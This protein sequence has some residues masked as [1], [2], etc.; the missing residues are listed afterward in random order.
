MSWPDFNSDHLIV[1]SKEM[2]DIEGRIFSAGLPIP[3]LMERAG[4]SITHWLLNQPG[5]IDS[6]VLVLVG[7]GHNGGDGL[8]VAR[9]LHHLGVEVFIWSPFKKQKPLTASHLAYAKWIGV[10]QV[11]GCPN[12]DGK[13]LWVEAFFGIGQSRPLPDSIQELFKQRE[14]KQPGRLI[15]IDVPAGICSDSGTS[16]QENS[17]KA[18]F[19]LTLGLIKKGLLQ[20]IALPNVGNLVRLD[21]G[22]SDAFL[23]QVL[24]NSPKN[25]TFNDLES[26]VWPKPNPE[27]SKYERGRLFIA[28]GSDKYRGAAFLTL[29]G[30]MASGVGSIQAALPKKVADQLWQVIPEVVLCKA[31]STSEDGSSLLESGLKENLLQ[32]IDALLIGPGLGVGEEKWENTTQHLLE[33][34][35]LLVLDADALNRMA[36]SKEGWQWLKKRNGPTWITPHKNEFYKLFPD[37]SFSSSLDAA[38]EAAKQSG[39]G[40]L[41]KGAHTVVADPDG[42]AWIIGQ[43]D[44]LS[45]R[46]GLGDVLAGFVAG[47]GAIGMAVNGQVDTQLLAASALAHSK[48]ASKCREGSAASQIVSCLAEEIKTM[49]KDKMFG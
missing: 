9:E 48:A 3:A 11:K 14:Q 34:L 6:G 49:N 37:I 28:S 32:R 43:A 16:F 35:G 30:A 36:S 19:T 5:L 24:Q 41:L 17:A 1:S 21:I 2:L 44:P 10:N 26:F 40:V 15:S 38:K 27:K 7:P 23:Y 12:P 39:V 25:I 29:K 13:E 45:A 33:F 20:D 4:Y 22:I 8:V 42:S 18:S 31:L 46:I 47:I